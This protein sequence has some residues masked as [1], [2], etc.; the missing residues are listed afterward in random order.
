MNVFADAGGPDSPDRA[1]AL[2]ALIAR[3]PEVKQAGRGVGYSCLTPWGVFVTTP[4]AAT[5]SKTPD[6]DRALV[7]I[8]RRWVHDML[9]IGL[10]PLVMMLGFD[11]CPAEDVELSR[12]DGAALFKSLAEHLYAA[13]IDPTWGTC[14]VSMSRQPGGPIE[15]AS[16]ATAPQCDARTRVRLI[17][18]AN[19]WLV[20]RRGFFGATQ[21]LHIELNAGSCWAAPGGDLGTA[22]AAEL[23]LLGVPAAGTA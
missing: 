5:P 20:S 17:S 13:G 8:V 23:D 11:D 19:D 10:A 16:V 9:G 7:D 18:A 4:D 15:V 3:Q 22:A 6:L 2:A 14:I 12:A 1:T 21:Q